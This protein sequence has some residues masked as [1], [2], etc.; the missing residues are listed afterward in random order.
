[1]KRLEGKVAIVTGGSRGIGRAI[2]LE[3]ARQGCKVAVNYRTNAAAAEEVVA[4]IAREGGQA[5]ATC[6]D[7]SVMAEA[8]KLVEATLGA[9]GTVDILVNNAGIARDMLLLRMSEADWDAVLDTNL[10]GAFAC[11]KA[12]Q[13]VLLK[14]RS[15]RIINIGSV[16]GLAGNV[17]QA[18]Y[19]AAKAGLVGLTKALAKELGSRNIT[20]NLVAP[21]FIQTDM[22]AKLSNELVEKALAQIPLAR[23]GRAEDVAAVVAFLASD[24]AQYITGQVLC[25]DGG[26]AM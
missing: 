9:F 18:N 3:L 17:G 11:I 7:V 19:A 22:T 4:L 26:L 13:R 1:M 10:K 25:V 23:L 15:G 14:K 20:V 2:A 24:A 21:G 16:V 5:Q 8:E 6:A 12:V